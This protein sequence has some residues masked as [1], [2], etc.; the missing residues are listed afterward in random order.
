MPWVGTSSPRRILIS[1]DFPA[2]LAPISPVMP[3]AKATVRPPS[4][5]TSP[6]YTLVSEVVSM[7]VAASFTVGAGCAP[8]EGVMDH[9]LA[10]PPR[11]LRPP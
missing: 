2:P 5:V 8:V 1:V 7:T 4:A 6:G 3:G 9:S 10:G 11:R